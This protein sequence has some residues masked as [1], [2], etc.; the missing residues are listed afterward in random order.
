MSTRLQKWGNSLAVRI[1]KTFVNEMNVG[2]NASL[3]MDMKDGALVIKPIREKRWSL[4]SLLSRVT[5]ENKPVE[6]ET[7]DPKGKE[8]W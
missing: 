3:S 7:G 6:W 2:E 8:E 5:E 1:P 4:N